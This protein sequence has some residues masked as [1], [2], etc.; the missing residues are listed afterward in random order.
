MKKFLSVFTILLLTAI[1]IPGC[2]AITSTSSPTSSLQSPSSI[3]S[4]PDGMGK[5]TF[6]VM[7]PPPPDMAHIWVDVKNLEIHKAGGPWTTIAVDMEPFDLKG[8]V[9]MPAFLAD[10]I[11]D[12]GIYTQIRLDV[13]SVIIEVGEEEPYV[14]H[15]ARVPSGNIKLV[16]CFDVAEGQETEITIDFNGEKSVNVTGNGEYIFKPVIKLLIPESAK[17]GD[18]QDDEVETL[19]AVL[20]QSEDGAIAEIS[21]DPADL[22]TEAIHLQTTGD[23]GSG[24]E[25][26]IVIDLPSG[27]TLDD[28]ESISWWIWTESGYPPH[29]DI[30]MDHNGDGV[31]DDEDML[32]AEMAYNNFAGSELD[33]T[34]PLSPTI[35]VWLQTFE[36]NSGDGYGD[37]NNDTMLW[38]TKMGG[39]NDDAPWGTFLQWK[40]GGAGVTNPPGNGD[41]LG[42]NITHDSEVLRLEIEIDNWVLQSDAYVKGIEIV[43][44]GTVYIVVF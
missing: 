13:E 26:R 3:S 25:A 9:D 15:I 23:V 22:E 1:L 12:A 28:I 37:I 17:P 44:D 41:I 8:I 32:T 30:V 43:L 24:N 2:T 29:L 18:D 6:L 7:D 40:A 33:S 4:L 16:G 11:V 27:T 36:L 5:L 20:G 19:L 34:P 10:E 14:T 21:T 42:G 35:G 31:V 38:V 39:G